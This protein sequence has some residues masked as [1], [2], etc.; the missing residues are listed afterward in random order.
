MEIMLE[1][2]YFGVDVS[3]FVGAMDLSLADAADDSKQIF[4]GSFD[5]LTVQFGLRK[6]L[7]LSEVR[8]SRCCSGL[9]G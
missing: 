6:R 3:I 7:F 2:T 8:W 1:D 5:G 4:R 9:D